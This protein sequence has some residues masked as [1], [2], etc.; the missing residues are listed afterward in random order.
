LSTDHVRLTRLLGGEEL[1]WLVQ[2][3]RRRLERGES[4]DGTVTLASAQAT[5]R[6]AVHRLLG[7]RPRPGT[8]LSVS[9]PDVDGMLRRSGVCP[10]GLAAAVVALTGPVALKADAVAE[11]ELAWHQAFASLEAVVADRPVLA[12]WYERVRTTGLVR[13]LVGDPRAATDLLASLAAVI[14]ALPAD[15]EPLGAFAARTTSDAHALDDDRPLATLALGAAR[16]LSGLPAGTG[17]E[18]RREIWAGVGVLRDE[19]STTVLTL[20]LPGDG[21]TATGQALGAW[22]ETGQPVVLTL[23]QL[24]RNPPGLGLSGFTVS[25]CENPVVVSSAAD[26]LGPDCAPL[27]C[28][29]GQPGAAVMHLLRLLVSGGARLRYHGDFDWGGLRIGNVLFARLPCQPWRYDAVAYRTAAGSGVGRPLTGQPV[30]ARWDADLAP[31][32]T[33]AGLR[34]EEEHLLDDLL[35]DLATP[36][37]RIGGYRSTRPLSAEEVDAALAKGLGQ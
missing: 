37:P 10:D 35:A 12:E 23:R 21:A 36:G 13:R 16:I 18:W 29:S 32:M 11:R 28:T 4:L 7:R 14:T 24:V 20:G 6:D 25:V 27:V 9:L 22:R 8:A 34:I 26:R 5:Q 30:P 3:V 33:H 17:A 1:A 2:R 15:G 31:A 19:V